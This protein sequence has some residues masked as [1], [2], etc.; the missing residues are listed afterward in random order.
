MNLLYLT[1]A[2]ALLGWLSLLLSRRWNPI[3]QQRLLN[4]CPLTLLMVPVLYLLPYKF[5][6]PADGQ[7][8]HINELTVPELAPS[9]VVR[10]IEQQP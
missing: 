2:V 10:S 9:A 1:A 7:V 3:W 4:S 8:T 5:E 6:W